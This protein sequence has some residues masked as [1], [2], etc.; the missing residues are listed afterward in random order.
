[1][2]TPPGYPGNSENQRKQIHGNAHVIIERGTV[3]IDIDINIPAFFLLKCGLAL[4][5]K[6][7]G[8]IVPARVR[9]AL[10]QGSGH[11]GNNM[12]PWVVCLVDGMSQPHDDPALFQGFA[13]IG[14]NLVKRS[15][16]KQH[17]H[18]PGVRTAV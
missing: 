14:V 1:M 11:G 3:K 13:D 16:F 2:G 5:F 7:F 10:T 17:P 9:D 15:Y 4:G 18:D 8:K 6:G 12:G